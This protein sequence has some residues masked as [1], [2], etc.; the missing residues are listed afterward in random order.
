M[1][2]PHW[3]KEKPL[4]DPYASP[5]QL[6]QASASPQI[7]GTPVAE[8]HYYDNHHSSDFTVTEKDYSYQ[9]NY[10][11]AGKYRP[12]FDDGRNDSTTSLDQAASYPPPRRVNTGYGSDSSH[13]GGAGLPYRQ[14]AQQQPAKARPAYKRQDSD[15][16]ARLLKGAGYQ[17]SGYESHNSS[18]VGFNSPN[19]QSKSSIHPSIRLFLYIVG[20]TAL[21]WIPGIIA[22]TVYDARP[23]N[24]YKNPAVWQVGIFW[25]SCWLSSIWVGWWACRI[26]AFIIPKLLR[27]TFGAVATQL[28]HY[29]D[30]LV[31][32]EKYLAIFFWTVVLWI[33]W[34][35]IIWKNFQDP[36]KDQI[37]PSTLDPLSSNSTTII[38]TISSSSTADTTSTANLM[39]TLGRLWFGFVICAAVLLGEKL[40]I[41][42]I[43]YNFHRV[44]YEDRISTSKFH[45]KVLTTLYENSRDLH[46]KDT[47]LAAEQEVKRKSG[48]YLA[49][50]KLKR[51]QEKVK[52]AA[53]TSSSILGTVASEIA[54][55][56]VLQP[57]NPRSI[58]VSALN[59]RK[60]TQALARRIWY[61]FVPV[62]KNEILLDDVLPCFPDAI[63]AEAAFEVFDK[64]MNGDVTK[65]ELEAACLEVHRERLAL[66]ASMR[67]VDS[68]VGRLDS[69]FMS[70]FVLISLV[71]IAAL[72][73]VKFG[74]LVTSFGTIIL[75]LSWLI[76]STAQETL[77]AI[78]FLFVKHPY[79]VG[80]RVDIGDDSY[81]VKEMNLLTTVFKTTNGKNVMVSHAQ[82]ATKPIVN[83][84][85]SGPIEETFK[86]SVAFNTSF[87]QIEQ[88]RAKMVHWLDGEKRDFL[89]GLD[90]S[91]VDYEDQSSMVLSAGIRYKSNWQMGGLKAQRR[92]RWLCQLKIFLAECRIFGPAGDPNA[93]AT[94]RVTM[95]P[96]PVPAEDG[97]VG[98]SA[99]EGVS[100]TMGGGERSYRFMD[101]GA[102]N[103]DLDA[104]DDLAG[105]RT[106]GTVPTSRAPSP[107]NALE[108]GRFRPPPGTGLP[109]GAAAPPYLRRNIGRQ[110]KEAYE[111]KGSPI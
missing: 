111:M 18:T 56:A 92:N 65:E 48:M 5:Q 6:D 100:K 93:L 47:Y 88:L 49:K 60:Q 30:Y 57:N 14:P 32:V 23:S 103:G 91:V 106:P 11:G 67:D 66:A 13:R 10:G 90:I 43:A 41:Q 78:L 94:K 99:Q 27:H 105:D 54:G 29:I 82:L 75:G 51:T 71:I 62:G 4:R 40:I 110:P 97:E 44:S 22:L 79:D 34:L 108:Q 64:D 37:D 36:A 84:R 74:S 50:A 80:D 2:A 59:S 16:W 21:L 35:V 69:I 85:R 63:T 52:I 109:A 61:S 70:F 98:T 72:L 86:F 89:P 26:A 53:Q 12:E 104:F 20:P 19:G 95:V 38:P 46:R 24:D 55:Q 15:S 77:A 101:K 39:V 76:G 7:S 73:S 31:A 83:L 33:V 8:S 102:I 28:K 58:V 81:I 45:I 3:S 96:Y 25:W 1:A 9:P 87:Q 42:G 17:N 68:A 107:A